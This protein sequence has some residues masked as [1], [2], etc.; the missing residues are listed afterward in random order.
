VN[1]DD[2]SIERL[3]ARRGEKWTTYPEDVLPAWVADMDFP[4]A[5]PLQDYFDE[6]RENTDYGYPVNPTPAALPSA[7]AQRVQERF[8]WNIDPRSIEVLTDVVQ[9]LYIALWNLTEP[10]DGAVVQTPVYPPFLEAVAECR[11]VQITNELVVGRER[12]EIDFDALRRAA[13]PR[14]RMLLLCH[15]QN[16]TGRAFTRAELERLAELA[17]ERDWLVVS[18]EIHADLVYPPAV[19]VPFAALGPEIARRTVTLA[20]AT[21]AFNIAGLRCAVAHFGSEELQRRFNALPR[22]VRGGVES[23]GL[24]ATQIAWTRCQPWL[25]AVLRYLEGNR[26][27]VTAFVRERLP[28]VRIFPP[29]ATYLAWLDCRELDL[30]NDPQRFFLE[31]ARVALSRG[32]NFGQGGAGFVRLNFATS[33]AILDQ[34][35]E[36]MASASTSVMVSDIR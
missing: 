23:L 32:P 15:P 4:V 18:D 30:P 26:D 3:R 11:R 24:H 6:L 2:L 28:G 25:D 31:K 22:H 7:F 29:E 34:A 20:S 35:L 36:R 1:F 12:Y 10:G 13:G 8:G 9:G 27:L 19:H 33:R 16:P 5:Q 14:T 17:L 21:K